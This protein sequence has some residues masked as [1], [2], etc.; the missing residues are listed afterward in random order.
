[1]NDMHIGEDVLL[2]FRKISKSFAG[3]QALKDVSFRIKKGEVH[4]LIGEN[5]AGKS[6][7]MKILAGAYSKDEGEILIEGGIVDIRTPK[8]AENLGVTVI[9]QEFNLVPMLTV[10]ENIFLGRIPRKF[11]SG[12]IIDW[13]QVKDKAEA[14]LKDIDVAIDTGALIEQLGVAQQQMVEIAKAVSLKSKIVIM[15]EPTSALTDVET[16]KL[17]KVIRKL[18]SQ[19]VAVIFISHRLEE[20]FNIADNVTVLR[21][22]QYINTQP[23]VQIDKD[24][25]I[26]MMVGRPLS[27]RYPKKNHMIGEE[28]LKVENLSRGSVIKSTS[29]SVRQGEILGISGLMGSGRTEMIRLLFGADKKD[30]GTIMVGGKIVN[31]KSPKDAIRAGIGLVP[32]DRRYQGLVMELP[33]KDNVLL[34]NLKKVKNRLFLSRKL[35]KKIC[36]KY[37]EDLEIKTPGYNQIAKRLSGG[38]QQKVVL[39]KWLN[40]DLDII[41]FDEP[42]RGIDVNAKMGIYNIIMQLAKQKKAIIVISSELPEILGISDRILVMSE[43]EIKGQMLRDEATQEKIM[44]YVIGGD[45]FGR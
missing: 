42:T 13:K 20:I 22:G 18:K 40:C 3:V 11:K 43:G 21:D 36:E 35:E 19:G 41:V 39:A 8:D 5:G 28:I 30:S 10:G 37:I 29:F 32:E 17:F 25:L 4:A 27:Q 14:L 1:M 34:A 9:Y 6:T 38:N 12:P 7:L 15:D 26:E 24:R 45:N 2:E 23:V 33:V 16:K 31:I 44:A